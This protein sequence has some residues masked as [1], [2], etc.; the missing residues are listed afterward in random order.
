MP[1]NYQRSESV[2][3]IEAKGAQ[4]QQKRLNVR[5]GLCEQKKFDTQCRFFTS[6]IGV[7]HGNC[8]ATNQPVQKETYRA[9]QTDP[10]PRPFGQAIRAKS[11]GSGS[12]DPEVTRTKLLIPPETLKRPCVPRTRKRPVPTFCVLNQTTNERTKAAGGGLS[13]TRKRPSSAHLVPYLLFSRSVT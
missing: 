4:K 12:Q 3:N 11:E 13:W 2:Q 9:T 8:E 7:K 10:S 1:T 5:T 6:L